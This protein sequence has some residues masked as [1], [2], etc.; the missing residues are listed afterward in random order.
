M[1]TLAK[2]CSDNN[3]L[4]NTSK[5]KEVIFSNS[6]DNLE[7]ESLYTDGNSIKR[8]YEYKYLRYDHQW[9]PYVS[10]QR[11]KPSHKRLLKILFKA[12]TPIHKNV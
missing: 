5:T 3:V 8:A 10:T 6:R 9:W 7:P 4:L 12:P 2:W 11:R 1:T